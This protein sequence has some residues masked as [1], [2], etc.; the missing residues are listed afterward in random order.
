MNMKSIPFAIT[1]TLAAGL[2]LPSLHAQLATPFNAPI[3][4]TTIGQDL[5]G[6]SHGGNAASWSVQ[7]ADGSKFYQ[8]TSGAAT[9][10]STALWAMSDLNGTTSADWSVSTVFTIS[11]VSD[12]AYIGLYALGTGLNSLAFTADIRGTSM[13]I[14]AL[15]SPATTLTTGTFSGTN[16]NT[17]AAIGMVYTAT[18]SGTYTDS[19]LT[20]LSFTLSDGTNTTTISGNASGLALNASNMYFGV[21]NNW[22]TAGDPLGIRYESI[23]VTS[24]PEPS[25][26]V[27]LLGGIIASA[28]LLRRRFSK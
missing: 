3:S 16:L 11:D 22:T 25:S 7:E 19:I 15:G 23:S 13:R 27:A 6:V 10:S 28:V 21:R 9:G 8:Y 4:G 14:L 1:C 20:N 2:L 17:A 24:I 18:L 5:A 26:A 12:G